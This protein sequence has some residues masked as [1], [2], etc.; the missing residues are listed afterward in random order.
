MM[1]KET[2][3]RID[4]ALEATEVIKYYAEFVYTNDGSLDWGKTRRRMFDLAIEILMMCDDVCTHRDEIVDVAFDAIKTI[5]ATN[6]EGKKDNCE[7]IT[8]EEALKRFFASL[9]GGK[10]ESI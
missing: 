2:Q 3:Y 9:E 5:K 1:D 10:H 4:R 7:A 6:D 8:G